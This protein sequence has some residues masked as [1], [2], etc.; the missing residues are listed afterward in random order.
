MAV[1]G[2]WTVETLGGQRF[3]CFATMMV[4]AQAAARAAKRPILVSYHGPRHKNNRD[5]ATT[6]FRLFPDGRRD[7]TIDPSWHTNGRRE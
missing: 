4:R 7:P 2:P 5:V 1:G 6:N 3:T